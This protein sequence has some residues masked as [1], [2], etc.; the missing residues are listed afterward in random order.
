MSK[1]KIIRRINWLIKSVPKLAL[2]MIFEK[3]RHPWKYIFDY[4]TL[5][6]EKRYLKTNYYINKYF[7]ITID[8][9][10]Y[11]LEKGDFKIAI[12]EDY[13]NKDNFLFGFLTVFFDIIYPNQVKY[14]I[15]FIIIEGNYE[16][17]G[18][19][20]REGDYIIDAGA[21][22]GVFS[23]YASNKIGSEGKIFAFEPIPDICKILNNQ[24]RYLKYDN[25]IDIAEALGEKEGKTTFQYSN[26]RFGSSSKSSSGNTVGV[27][28]NTIDNYVKTNNIDRVDF[29]K[30]DIEGEERHALIGAKETIRKYKPRLSICIYHLKDDPEVI[31]NI[32]IEIRP[33]YKYKMTDY[34]I[35]AW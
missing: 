9:S 31:K 18:V 34:K 24:R 33:D 10:D 19:E 22:I 20:L 29:I 30:M 3:K 14:P 16:R 23:V 13:F 6:V 4:L 7:K 28:V 35:Y 2:A 32:I 5:S 1:E 15:P 17:Y 11:L 8:N 26:E 12:P 25:I 21:N 27:K